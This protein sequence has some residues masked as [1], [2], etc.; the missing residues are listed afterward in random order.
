MP[1]V[2]TNT[3]HPFTIPQ[4]LTENGDSKFQILLFNVITITLAAASLVVGYL[5][6]R[7]QRKKGGSE[8][9]AA[10]S[11]ED[12]LEG[13]NTGSTLQ[14]STTGDEQSEDI[15]VGIHVSHNDSEHNG[16]HEGSSIELRAVERGISH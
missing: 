10:E 3:T 14:A 12:E 16:E 8:E 2:P 9:E 7:Q 13:S 11:Q 5:H 15:V 1:A 6:L 4:T